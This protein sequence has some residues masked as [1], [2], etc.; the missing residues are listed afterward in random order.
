MRESFSLFLWKIKDPMTRS[1]RLKMY[2]KILF[3]KYYDGT[4]IYK[5]IIKDTWYDIKKMI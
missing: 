5:M 1:I 4:P 3:K 2:V